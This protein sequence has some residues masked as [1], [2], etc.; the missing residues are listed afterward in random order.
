LVTEA[1]W[2][3]GFDPRQAD[4]KFFFVLPE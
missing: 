3:C 2:N 1:K 4:G